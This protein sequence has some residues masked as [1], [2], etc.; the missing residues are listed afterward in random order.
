MEE[1]YRSA[2]DVIITDRLSE[3]PSRAPDFAAEN[4]A[5]QVLST[6]LAERPETLL[7]KLAETLVELGIADSAGVSIEETVG[8][9]QF[10][11]AA[12]AGVWSQFRWGTIP[13]DASPCGIAVERD[14]LMLIESPERFFPGANAG[15]LIHEGLLLPFHAG[16]RPVGTVWINAHNAKRKFDREDARL[17]QG[18]AH[19]AS[20]GY[21]M[22]LA[23]RSAEAGRLESASRL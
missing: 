7:Q 11:W 3:R 2:D 9:R 20:A 14:K 8:G 16:G 15:P 12:L 4:Q 21:Q 10:R 17:L 1:R 18:L 5:L 19:F 22:S 13:F 23:L 6:E